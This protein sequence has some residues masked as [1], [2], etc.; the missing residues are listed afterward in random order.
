MSREFVELKRDADELLT[1]I[2]QIKKESISFANARG[3]LNGVANQLKGICDKLQVVIQNSN[4]LTKE[5]NS[6]AVKN[7]VQKLSDTEI[8]VAKDVENIR[9]IAVATKS[10]IEQAIASIKKNVMIMGGISIVCSIAA[11]IIAV[12]H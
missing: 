3:E 1:S 7:T 10:E 8:A 2:E 9:D 6:I 4:A 11:I 5:V 12:M